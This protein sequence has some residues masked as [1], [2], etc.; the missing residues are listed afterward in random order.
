MPDELA[1]EV[2]REPHVDAVVPLVEVLVA[3][4]PL[5]RPDARIVGDRIELVMVLRLQRHEPDTPPDELYVKRQPSP[6]S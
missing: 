1:V 6:S 4:D 3:P 5:Q 2:V